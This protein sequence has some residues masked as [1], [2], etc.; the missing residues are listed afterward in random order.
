LCIFRVEE[1]IPLAVTGVQS[2]LIRAGV[3]GCLLACGAL[4][5]T[6]LAQKVEIQY[7]HAADFS[8]SLR[9][10]WRT[11]PVFEKNPELQ[12]LYATA[13]QLV[14]EAG[15]QQLMKRGLQPDDLSPDIFITFFVLTKEA[16]EV[17][18]TVLSGWGDA[19]SWYG[20]PTWTVTEVEDY[21]R[22]MLVIEILDAHT[23]KLLWR[24]AGGDKIKEMRK[25]DQNINAIVRKALERFPPK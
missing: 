14:L 22:G 6:A 23:S 13:I 7:D 17:K 21:L 1:G 9:Y 25:R 24:A 15:N 18:T 10:Q 8:R 12:Q 20:V 5:F 19:Y 2:S 11:H 4:T 3:A 16:Q